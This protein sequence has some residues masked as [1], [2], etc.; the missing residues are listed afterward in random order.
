[1]T[2]R[3]PGSITRTFT[4]YMVLVA[5]LAVMACGYLWISMEIRRFKEDSASLRERFL[6]NRQQM[7]RDEVERAADF[8][9]YKKSQTR[10]RLKEEIRNRTRQAHAIAA[11]LYESHR[12]NRS[13]A[14]IKHLVKDTLGS[15][16]FNNDRGY[17]FATDL[18]GVAALFADHPEME[19][20][21]LLG[22]RDTRGKHVI[23]DMIRIASARG[24]G[25]YEYTWTKPNAEGR[26]FPK[27]AFIQYFE[28]FDWLIG[29]GEYI[30]DVTADIQAEVLDRI[31]RR[32]YGKA[33]YIFAGQWDGLSLSGPA[34]G[35]N[36]RHVTDTGGVKIVQ[37]LID[38]A[39]SGGGFVR[40]NM[41]SLEGNRSAPKLSYATGIEDWQWYVGAGVYLD[42]IDQ[43]IAQRQ[44]AMTTKLKAQL[45]KLVLVLV[46]ILGIIALA[47]RY[48]ARKTGSNIAL[49]SSFFREAASTSAA[50]DPGAVHFA[51]FARLARSANRMVDARIQA[52]S[53]KKKSEERFLDLAELLPEAI[54]EADAKGRLTF[55]NQKAYDYFA[56][57]PRDLDR[58]LNAL[59]MIVEEDRQDTRTDL[60]RIARGERLG[61]SE[62]TAL[63]KDGSRFP[64]MRHITAVFSENR[65]VGFRGFIIDISEKKNLEIQ[66]RQVQKME[67]IGTLAGGIAHDF[68]NILS[69]ILGYAELSLVDAA[70]GSMTQGHLLKIFKAGERARDLVGQIL[71]FS[72]Q[73][74]QDLMPIQIRPIAEEAFKLLRASLPATIEIHQE[75]N[76]DAAI[77]GDPTQIHQ[78]IM[79]LVTNAAHA[80]RDTG[81]TLT[82]RLDKVTMNEKTAAVHPGIAPGP[83]IQMTVSDTG[84]G[85]HPDTQERIFD[86]FFTTKPKGEGTGMGLSVVHG[87]VQAHGGA[88]TLE[89]R[90]FTGTTFQIFLPIIENEPTRPPLT[91]TRLP[92]GNERILFVD[93][94]DFQVD[95]GRQMLEKLGYQVTTSNDSINALKTFRRDFKDFDLVITDM[96]MPNLTGDE[97]ARAMMAIEPDIPVI[98]CTGFSDRISR[99]KATAIGIREFVLKPIVFK[100]LAVIIRRVLD[101]NDEPSAT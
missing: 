17:Y 34:R 63:R 41:P 20:E 56:Y 81:G 100:D 83:Y 71:T 40:Y 62:L 36:M 45:I 55:V 49:F 73:A 84:H 35:K 8:I 86:P 58:G 22:I 5:T 33:G 101:G 70:P 94:E 74:D 18:H 91:A 32:Q 2:D 98:I 67:A 90:P 46:A 89:S 25:F 77:L 38:A 27:I 54:F 3:S 9:R 96:T 64:A 44:S 39:K 47:A 50:I 12:H 53:A 42:E 15:I 75:F 59:D 16:R 52:E 85:I 65:L 24:E 21:N 69:A 23:Q 43:V 68:N 6:E 10:S 51:E 80:M 92:T 93:D 11:H 88:I 61:L 72:R 76:T 66:L 78:I 14:E 19:G 99:E 1:M 60:A 95:L 30:D 97:L 87:I 7:L 26:H 31:S 48:M 29:T 13:G 37:A 82:F 57:T 79:N 4:L 28:P